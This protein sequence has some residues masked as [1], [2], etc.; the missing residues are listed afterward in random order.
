MYAESVHISR[1]ERETYLTIKVKNILTTTL[2][3]VGDHQLV[4]IR[5]RCIVNLHYYFYLTHFFH[6]YILFWWSSFDCEMLIEYTVAYLGSIY[7]GGANFIYLYVILKTNFSPFKLCIFNLNCM[8]MGGR[9]M[10]QSPPFK[11]AIVGTTN[12]INSVWS[13]CFLNTSLCR[14]GEFNGDII[15]TVEQIWIIFCFWNKDEIALRLK[16]VNLIKT[17]L[18]RSA[19]ISYFQQNG[20][21]LKLIIVYS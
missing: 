12:W 21:V 20:I 14:L 11:S 2:V 8:V 13:F 17:Q 15:I 18:S 10:P 9:E 19:L 4:S 16:T 3:C 1:A 7:R 5:E 6:C